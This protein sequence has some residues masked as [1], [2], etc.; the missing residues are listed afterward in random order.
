MSQM[1]NSYVYAEYCL[2]RILEKFYVGTLVDNELPVFPPP[3]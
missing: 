1:D 2:Y 3:R